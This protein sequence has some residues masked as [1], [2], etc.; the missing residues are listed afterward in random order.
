MQPEHLAIAI[1]AGFMSGV[2]NTLA[3]SG[4]VFTLPVLLFLG[5]PPHMANGTNRVGILLQTFVGSWMLYFKGGLRFSGDIKYV[6]P[7]MAGSLLGAWLAVDIDEQYLKWTIAVVM[8]M[9]LV[10]TLFRYGDLLRESDAP[11]NK[12][13]ELGGYPLLFII[14]A[15]GGFIQ[16]GVGIFTLAALV[17][18]LNMTLK[19]ANALKNMMNFCLTLPAFLVFAINGQ[20]D[21]KLGA[22]IA[23]GQVIGAF[24]AARY[25]NKSDMAQLWIRRLLIAMMVL[26]SAQLFGLID[27]IVARLNEIP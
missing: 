20:V 8:L 25:A 3:G 1:A 26:T 24:V 22:I 12:I 6:L 5:L 17:L 7:T 21:W 4:S 2:I 23:F 15:Y 13:K 18:F 10:I 16:L 11:L 27:W 9:L 14:G 19:H